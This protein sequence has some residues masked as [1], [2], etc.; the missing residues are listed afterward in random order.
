M[1]NMMISMISNL[2]MSICVPTS[3]LGAGAGVYFA[4]WLVPGFENGGLVI[5]KQRLV[6]GHQNVQI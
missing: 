2:Q 6:G 3:R 4:G 1:K 5:S